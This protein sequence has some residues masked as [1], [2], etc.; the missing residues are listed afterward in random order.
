MR[1][2]PFRVPYV[3]PLVYDPGPQPFDP[4][5]SVRLYGGKPFTLQPW[6]NSVQTINTLLSTPGI[7]RMRAPVAVNNQY[8]NDPANYLFISGFVGKSKG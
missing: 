7:A 1:A 3:T 4:G 8:S 2:L 5:E 6:P